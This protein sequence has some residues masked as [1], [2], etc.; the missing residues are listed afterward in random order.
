MELI[1]SHAHVY[2]DQ[3]S[4]DLDEVID[5]AKEAGIT[6]IFMPNIDL[7]TV[8]DMLEVAARYRGY[9]FPMIGLHPCSVDKHFEKQLYQLEDWL[10]QE[11]FMAIGEIGTD[12]YWD[13]TYWEQQQ[14]ALKIQVG[15][16]I[17]KQ[18]PFVVHCRNS[19]ANDQDHS[20]IRY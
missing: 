1:D 6:A 2:L 7:S 17:E 4:P 3:F 11:N 12:L 9:C 16:G 18:L 14:E 20:G 10:D 5:R 13:E 19:M 8:E 15:W